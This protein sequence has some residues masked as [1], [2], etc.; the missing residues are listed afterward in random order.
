MN[1]KPSEYTLKQ[2]RVLQRDFT[3]LS[4]DFLKT[5]GEAQKR[6]GEQLKRVNTEI[7]TIQNRIKNLEYEAKVQ[8]ASLLG[9][10]LMEKLSLDDLTLGQVLFIDSLF[11]S[12]DKIISNQRGKRVIFQMN[13]PFYEE[14]KSDFSQ[15]VVK[16]ANERNQTRVS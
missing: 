5:E 11:Q 2:L 6:I 14:L 3:T 7:E 10:A 12:A 13:Q 8:T 1:F 16:K 4:R 15:N 9:F